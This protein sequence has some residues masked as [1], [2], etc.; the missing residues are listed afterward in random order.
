MKKTQKFFKGDLVMVGEMPKSMEHFTHNCKAI[1]IHSGEEYND[2]IG[3]DQ[4][5]LYILKKG[6]TGESCWYNEDQLTLIEP[7]RF[8]MLPKSHV[9][10]RV[11]EAKKE[12]EQ[13]VYRWI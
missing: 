9:H 3:S 4:Y 2:R 12:R 1:V 10:R 5:C 6:R 13:Y 8:D 7:N 11:Y